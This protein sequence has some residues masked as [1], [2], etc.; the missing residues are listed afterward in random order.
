MGRLHD[1]ISDI[2]KIIN[3]KGGEV[4]FT[5]VMGKKRMAYPIQKQK[6]GSYVLIQF[7]SDGLKNTE[8]SIEL[9]HNPNILR[10]M[11]ISIDESEVKEQTEEVK[12]QITGLARPSS[13]SEEKVV[14]K[15]VSPVET[16]AVEEDAS[17]EE[18]AEKTEATEE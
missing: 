7:K 16:K 13:S 17:S 2:E 14:A 4:I 15:E 9:E 5:N 1:L 10:Q 3:E 6:F 11:I 18:T 8:L 12:D